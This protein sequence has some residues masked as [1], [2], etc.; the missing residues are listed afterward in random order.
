MNLM[1]V[2]DKTK[3]VTLILRLAQLFSNHILLKIASIY[4]S[5]IIFRHISRTD[6]VNRVSICIILDCIYM[7]VR[8]QK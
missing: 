7:A 4:I 1:L 6:N 3:Q 5:K 2:F 8:R